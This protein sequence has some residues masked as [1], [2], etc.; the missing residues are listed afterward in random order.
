M[1]KFVI[2]YPSSLPLDKESKAEDTPSSS[3]AQNQEEEDLLGRKKPVATK[4]IMVESSLLENGE[5][6]KVH[7]P[8]SMKT[9]VLDKTLQGLFSKDEPFSLSVNNNRV[10]DIKSSDYNCRMK[11]E[12][13]HCVIEYQVLAF[14]NP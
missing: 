6:L 8:E 12:L 2:F 5:L 4:Q 9:K 13:L 10:L 1:E 14:F 3:L 11:G 7:L